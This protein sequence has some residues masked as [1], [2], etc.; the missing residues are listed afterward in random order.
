VKRFL[1]LAAIATLGCDGKRQDKTTV[2][3]L[4]VERLSDSQLDLELRYAACPG[5]ARRVVRLDK[6]FTACAG[7]IQKGDKLETE[8]VSKWSSDRGAYRSEIVRLGKCPVKLD[9]KEEANYEMVQVC[10]DVIAT[11]AVVGV[12]CDRSRP[13]DLIAKCPWLRRH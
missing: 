3:V 10:S 2:E 11:G 5:D 9:P 1:L 7:D 4:Q 13:K 8:I 12:R 6:T